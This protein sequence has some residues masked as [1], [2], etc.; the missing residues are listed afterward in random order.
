MPEED[1]QPPVPESE[2]NE[3]PKVTK[4]DVDKFYRDSF[5]IGQGIEE[6]QKKFYQWAEKIDSF[7]EIKDIRQSH[8]TDA[9]LPIPHVDL[10]GKGMDDIRMK[11]RLMM[12]AIGSEASKSEPDELAQEVLTGLIERDTYYSQWGR[13]NKDADAKTDSARDKYASNIRRLFIVKNI[14]VH[15]VI[16]HY[17]ETYV[18]PFVEKHKEYILTDKDWSNIDPSVRSTVAELSFLV[19]EWVKRHPGKTKEDYF[20]GE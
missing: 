19:E 7:S 16:D 6:Y 15:D 17:G 20:K 11:T 14:K 1:T 9:A 8:I 10:P 4:D 13:P 12:V 18:R 2:R 5:H 3:V